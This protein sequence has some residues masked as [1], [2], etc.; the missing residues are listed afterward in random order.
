MFV[1]IVESNSSD[2][3]T[4]VFFFTN[5][6]SMGVGGT[7]SVLAASAHAYCG[8]NSSDRKTRVLFFP[9][10]CSMG[11]GGTF[12]VLACRLYYYTIFPAY[13]GCY[14]DAK[15]IF[16]LSHPTRNCAGER[17]FFTYSTLTYVL[18][19][20]KDCYI[21]CFFKQFLG[22]CSFHVILVKLCNNI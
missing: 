11:V 21:T 9:N 14:L 19:S 7:F 12:S 16:P 22:V 6:C 20:C 15:T 5:F 3:K 4:R 2:R 8:T 10:F 1:F 17:S 18:A 13:L